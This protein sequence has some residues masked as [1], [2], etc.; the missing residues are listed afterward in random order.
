MTMI[1][2][3]VSAIRH[4]DLELRLCDPALRLIGELKIIAPRLNN[5][6]INNMLFD[7]EERRRLILERHNETS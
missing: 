2:N 7:Y 3:Y 5:E 4:Y 1:L 6:F